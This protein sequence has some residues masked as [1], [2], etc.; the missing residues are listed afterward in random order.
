[1]CN[2]HLMLGQTAVIYTHTYTHSH[3]FN[4][5][6]QAQYSVN[7]HEKHAHSLKRCKIGKNA[8]WQV[9]K[10]VAVQI[11]SP[12]SKRNRELGRQLSC[13]LRNNKYVY[14]HKCMHVCMYD[15]LWSESESA[16]HAR[17][18]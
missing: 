14:I 7:S 3:T 1:M 2:T 8:G 12:V 10:L 18:C 17:A 11:K 15:Y 5:F 16:V 6:T 13:I 9:R 4:N